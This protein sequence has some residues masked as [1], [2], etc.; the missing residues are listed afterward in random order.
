MCY[1]IKCDTVEDDLMECAS[2]GNPGGIRRLTRCYRVTRVMSGET[3]NLVV[4]V[5]MNENVEEGPMMDNTELLEAWVSS[6]KANLVSVKA[7]QVT[8]VSQTCSSY[9]KL[10]GSDQGYLDVTLAK[11]RVG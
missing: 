10:S 8:R 2:E 3:G 9:P 1:P 4:K 6:G 7:N 11:L 5:D